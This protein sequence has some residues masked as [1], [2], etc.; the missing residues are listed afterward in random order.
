VHTVRVDAV[1]HVDCHHAPSIDCLMPSAINACRDAP[2]ASQ[3]DLAKLLW[4]PKNP[5]DGPVLIDAAI[6]KFPVCRVSPLT[7]T[8]NRHKGKYTRLRWV[9]QR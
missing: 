8:V 1:S 5:A 9:R 3:L 4:S 7:D 6:G 2:A